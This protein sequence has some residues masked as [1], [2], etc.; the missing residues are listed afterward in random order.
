[1]KVNEKTVLKVL[2][3]WAAQENPIRGWCWDKNVKNAVLGFLVGFSLLDGTCYYNVCSLDGYE[4]SVFPAGRTYVSADLA[5]IMECSEGENYEHFSLVDPNLRK[6]IS[7]G[8][9]AVDYLGSLH[10]ECLVKIFNNIST[11]GSLCTGIHK[12]GVS[13]STLLGV[14]VQTGLTEWTP[15]TEIEVVE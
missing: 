12:D 3:A 10:S 9:E 6:L 4:A 8:E 2:E 15:I 13:S 14:R 11:A 1:M 5:D 7:E